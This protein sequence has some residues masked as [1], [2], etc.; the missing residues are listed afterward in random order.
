MSVLVLTSVLGLVLLYLGLFN[1]KRALAPVGIL[2]LLG[3]IALLL[4]DARFM[5]LP[6]F[7][8]MFV[9]DDVARAFAIGLLVITLLIFV[10]GIDYYARETANV[11]EQYALLMF[12]LTGAL[13]IV[14]YTN[15]LTLFLGIEVLSIPLYILA[16]G[17]RTSL[18]S[19]EASFKY[20]LLGSFASAFLL[21]GIALIYGQAGSF[22]LVQVQGAVATHPDSVLLLLGSFAVLVA[23]AFKVGAVPFHFWSPDVYEGAPTLV[24]AFMATVVKMS[25]FAALYRLVMS[26]NMPVH[27]VQMLL[28]IAIVTLLLGNLAALRQSHFKRLMAYSSIAHSGFLLLAILSGAEEVPRVLFYYTLTYGLATVGLFVVM[29]IAK[30]AA[31]GDEQLRIFRGLFQARP[32]LGAITLVLLLSLAGIP[33]T[34]GFVAKYRVFMLTLGAGYLAL[35]AFAV[36]MAVVGIYYYAVV[37]RE[38][39]TAAPEEPRLIVTPGNTL[40]LVICGVAAVALA[41]VPVGF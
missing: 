7:A 17:K 25:A 32:W 14:G 29:T 28:A 35:T 13:M 4:F 3:G 40:V 16:G 41:V 21:M 15:L 8:N 26:L 33:L 24:T 37:V 5:N 39:F 10:F 36:L 11:A 2:G 23:M 22:E 6:G 31:N 20:F 12:S 9:F 27:V 19:G 30:R 34:A 18:R 38:S 1:G